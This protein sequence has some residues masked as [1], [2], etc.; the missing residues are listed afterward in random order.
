MGRG[1]WLIY[2]PL[3]YKWDVYKS[4]TVTVKIFLYN[5]KGRLKFKKGGEI[6]KNFFVKAKLALEKRL[7]LL[8]IVFVLSVLV[9]VINAISRILKGTDWQLVSQQLMGRSLGQ[10]ALLLFGGLLAVSP[11]LIYDFSIVKFLPGKYSRAYIIKSGWITNTITNIAGFGGVLG[12]TLRA[13]FYSKGASKKQIFYALSKIALFLLAGL[14][15][16]SWLALLLIYG[17]DL[18]EHL[19]NYGLWLIGGALYFPLLF[20]VTKFKNNGFFADLSLRQELTLTV[21]STLEWLFVAGFFL[22]VGRI[23]G[24][25]HDLTAIFCLYII[26]SILGIVSM[27]PGGLGSFDVFMLI[28]MATFGI[29]RELALTWL[30]YFRIFYYI[31]PVMVGLA[32]LVHSMG[33]RINDYFDGIPQTFL[34]TLAHRILTIFLYFSGIFMLMESAVPS[35][36]VSNKVLVRFYPYTFFF[37]HQLTNICYAFILLGLA[38]GIQ[39]KVKKAYWPMLAVLLVGII[40]TLFQDWSLS[41]TIYLGIVL[42][43]TLFSKKALYRQKFQ[44]SLGSLAFDG[45]IFIGSFLLYVVIGVINAPAYSNK[46][47]IPS[48]LFFPGQ[49]LWLSGLIGIG[50]AV[51]ILYFIMQYLTTGRDPFADRDFESERVKQVIETFGGN[52]TSHLAFLRDKNFYFYQVDGVDQLF[53]MYRRKNDKLIIMGEP[54]GNQAYQEEALQSFLHQ[55][56]LYG[57]ELV[58]Y[59]V[60]KDYTMLLHE[61]GFD[62]LKTGED[63]LVELDKFTLVGKKQRAQRALMNKF[64]R[65]GYVFSLAPN[66]LSNELLAEMKRV[67]DEW[68]NGQVEKGFSLGFFDEYYLNQAPVALVR[69]AEGTLVAF[70]SMMPTGGKEILT[71]D[72][73]RHSKD[74][75]SGIMDEIFISL[76][77]YGQEEGY[78]YFD[79]GMAP[80][81]N[82]GQSK[83]SFIEERVAHLIYQYG[84][85]LYGFQGLRAY[86]NKYATVWHPKYTAY[87]KKSSL[88]S[89]MWQVIMVVNQRADYR[90]ANGGKKQLLFIPKFLQP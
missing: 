90:T 88:L 71:I 33:G 15:L 17:F 79:L 84:Y 89:T 68:L 7:T 41:L 40:N 21:G 69:D 8:K 44:Y 64:E 12:A 36:T 85:K 39:A 73:M 6:L 62:F 46:H 30:L 70:A 5:G 28:G 83:F 74:A 60:D 49:Q 50:I 82:V 20:I 45:V 72:L 3:F 80:L 87:R 37:L 34:A 42:A 86:K 13:S 59:E 58:F 51:I 31:V 32:F 19:A 16:L 27:L 14:S 43:I 47:K 77:K 66:P 35:L 63:G 11:M 38:R 29:N 26:A 67:S 23:L 65:E 1:L 76:F 18:G 57:Y 56:D 22:L 4:F 61:Y 54:V 2:G 81:S 52:E 9:F 78:T 75:P 53:F 25:N 55:A 24:V 48:V 10:L